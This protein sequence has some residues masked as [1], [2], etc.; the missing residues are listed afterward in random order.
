MSLAMKLRMMRSRRIQMDLKWMKVV[1]L[2]YLF[3]Y[4][5]VKECM[6]VISVRIIVSYDC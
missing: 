6:C 2:I 5:D 1:N 3:L 4:P